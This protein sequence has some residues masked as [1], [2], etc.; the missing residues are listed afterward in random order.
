[1]VAGD[2][3][4]FRQI[5]NLGEVRREVTG[6]ISEESQCKHKNGAN[7]DRERQRLGGVTIGITK[8]G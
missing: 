1:M 2:R 5:N 7:G 4:N 8:F 6:D 3:G